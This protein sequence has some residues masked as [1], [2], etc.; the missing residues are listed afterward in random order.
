MEVLSRER[1]AHRGPLESFA[2]Q[3]VF[4][5][6]GPV[7]FFSGLLCFQVDHG[8]CCGTVKLRNGPVA[9]G[10]EPLRVPKLFRA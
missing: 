6:G 9:F 10:V 7:M 8:F 3:P 4:C 5:F 1:W 2:S